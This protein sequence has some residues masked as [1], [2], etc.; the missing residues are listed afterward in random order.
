[1]SRILDGPSVTIRQT[2]A[3]QAKNS[4]AA[5]PSTRLS[6]IS[7]RRV[8]SLV[9]GV[10]IDDHIEMRLDPTGDRGDPRVEMGPADLGEGIDAALGGGPPVGV[11]P[12]GGAGDRP[13]GGDHHLP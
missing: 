11:V 2:L 13:D 6:P 8:G 12:V 9:E 5:G 3:S 4:M 1:M 7:E 10:E